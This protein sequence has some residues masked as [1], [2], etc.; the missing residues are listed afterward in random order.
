MIL[1]D[2]RINLK[3]RKYKHPMDAR[4]LSNETDFDSVQNLIKSVKAAYPMAQRYYALKR[5][6]LGLDSLY[7]Y[8][9]YAPLEA[10]EDK[11]DFNTCKA[12]VIKYIAPIA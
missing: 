12:S 9:R 1:A 4:N 6:L 8:D 3:I 5:R 10:G 7:D 11:V 2:H